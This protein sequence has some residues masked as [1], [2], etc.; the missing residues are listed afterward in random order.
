MENRYELDN[1]QIFSEAD[2]LK[3]IGESQAAVKS[4]SYTWVAPDGT[5]YWVSY[6]ADENGYHPSVGMLWILSL[7]RIFSEFNCESV[8]RTGTGGVGNIGPGEDAPD[9]ISPNASKPLVGK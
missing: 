1:R 9:Y 7:I 2:Q 4:G 3:Q 8:F 6:T 5:I